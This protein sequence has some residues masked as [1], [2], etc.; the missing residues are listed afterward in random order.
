MSNSNIKQNI[1]RSID[2]TVSKLAAIASQH[3]VD[4]QTEARKRCRKKDNGPKRTE[5]DKRS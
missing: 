5:A 2:D 3:N 1:Y 4:L